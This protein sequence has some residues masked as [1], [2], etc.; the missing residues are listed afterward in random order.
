MPSG[1]PA[2]CRRPALGTH[3]S[4]QTARVGDQ[5]AAR[6]NPFVYF[7]SLL[8]SGAC[9]RFDLPLT[10]LPRDLRSAA[11]TPNYSFI[12]PNLCNDGHD[13]PCV[14][15][16]P[17]GLTS[18][19]AFLRA[20]VPKILSS[21]AY[22][23]G[24]MLVITFDESDGTD[25]SACCE[26]PQFPNTPNNGFIFPGRG[27]GRVGAVVLSPFIDPGTVDNVAYNH[28]S[29]LRSIEDLFGLG[30]IGYAAQAGLQAMGSDLF[31]CYKPGGPPAH[32]GKLPAG[33]VIKL[34]V[35]GQG[36]APRPSVEVKLWYPGRVSVKVYRPGGGKSRFVGGAHGL[37]ACQLLK[38]TLPYQHG[39]LTLTAHAF[40]AVERRTIFF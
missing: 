13:A 12:T 3:D 29:L 28:F 30:H 21:P 38:V 36:T 24:G 11:T 18:A 33:S 1:Q 26:E 8:D 20:W 19:N 9:A 2:T 15:H 25:A 17:G 34:A 10:A 37:A 16:R 40:R 14:D 22:H 6:H 7:H 35:I 31:T 5:Y 32:H 23:D 4:T 27:G 39:R